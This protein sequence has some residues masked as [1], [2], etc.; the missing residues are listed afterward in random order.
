MPCISALLCPFPCASPSPASAHPAV[1]PDALVMPALEIGGAHLGI[2]Q[3]ILAGAAHGH[4][5]VDHHVTAMRQLERAEGIL[6]DQEYSQALRLVELP[7][8]VEDLPDDQRCQAERRL[9]Q[10]Q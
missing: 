5:A 4:A 6:L 10:H 1:S 3:Q 7:D 2:G 9:V 8:G